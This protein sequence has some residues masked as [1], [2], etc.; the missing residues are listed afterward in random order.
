MITKYNERKSLSIT[1]TFVMI[2]LVSGCY[3]PDVYKT[4]VYQGNQFEQ[5]NV[6]QL[7]IGMTKEQVVFLLGNPVVRDSFDPSK[8]IYLARVSLDNE[9]EI[10]SKIVL[11]FKQDKLVNIEH[12]SF[13]APLDQLTNPDKSLSADPSKRAWWRVL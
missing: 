1:I 7:E 4:K 11:Q 2:L 13:D 5:G 8:W 6:S 9:A 12:E 3:F 10:N